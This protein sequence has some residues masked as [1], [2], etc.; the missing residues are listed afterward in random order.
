MPAE[1]EGAAFEELALRAGDYA[2]AM[3]AVVLRRVD[4]VARDVRVRVG[5]VTDRPTALPEA[6]AGGRAA[7]PLTAAS[8]REAGARRGRGRRPARL[9]PRVRRAICG[10]STG[11]LVERALLRAW[12]RAA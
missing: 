6:E 7:A 10:T 1:G 12:E 2:L 9:D 8:A 3:V 4:G 5:A 11:T